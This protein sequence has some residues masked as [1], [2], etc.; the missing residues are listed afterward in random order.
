MND[1][2]WSQA[3]FNMQ[4]CC[5][6]IAPVSFPIPLVVTDLS[7][8]YP[9]AFVSA[10]IYLTLKHIVLTIGEEYSR[11]QARW[12]TWIFIL[13][14]LF[15]L[16]LQGA[17]GGIAATAN[18][19]N[20]QKVGNNL[21]MAGIVFQ[22][23]T[24]LVFG[25]LSGLYARTAYANRNSFSQSTVA[26]LASTKFKLFILSLIVAWITIFTRCVY[27]IAEMAGGWGNPIMQNEP[28]FIV[29]ENVM[30]LIATLCLTVFHPGYCFPQ[31][32]MADKHAGDV[33]I[34]ETKNADI[35]SA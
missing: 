11:L 6:I 2:P 24:F 28:E 16:V 20:M 33:A 9:K 3:G 18:D 8:V 17:G 21:M 25:T 35:E 27:R 10:G 14:D 12:Y 29:L 23:F 22:V 13:C 19:E 15:S 1:N 32:Q 26:L 31:M 4:I 34:A 5:L 7:N 30:I